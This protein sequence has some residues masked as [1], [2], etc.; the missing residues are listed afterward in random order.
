V[1]RAADR[2]P[3]PVGISLFE[4]DVALSWR[5]MVVLMLTISDNPSTDVLIRRLGIDTLNTTAARLGMSD[6]VVKFDVM[7]MLDSIGHDLGHAGWNDL[8]SWSAAAPPDESARADESLLTTRALDP[9][10]GTRTSPRDMIT[11]LRLI[12]NGQAGPPGACERIRA[13][14]ARQLTRDRIASAFRPPVRVAAKSGSLVGVAR[15]EIGVISY[16]D[17]RRY[18][19]AVFTRSRP[20]SGNAAISSAI[21]TATAHAVASLVRA[22]CERPSRYPVRASDLWVM[23]T[24]TRV[25][26]SSGGLRPP[27]WPRETSSVASCQG[28]CASAVSLYPRRFQEDCRVRISPRRSA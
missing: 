26:L 3:G 15:N 13:L 16:P 4:D 10:K 19:A 17:G 24:T 5:D 12:W 25:S 20:G 9:R 7:T 2:T 21:G 18:A 28:C 6:T 27:R 8:I 22:P 11:L 23:S 14:M 1:L